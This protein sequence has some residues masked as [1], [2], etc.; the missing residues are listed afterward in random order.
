MVTHPCITF[1]LVRIKK[2]KLSPKFFTFDNVL[3]YLLDFFSSPKHVTYGDNMHILVDLPK[4][5]R[6]FNSKVQPKITIPTKPT[7]VA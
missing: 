4:L 3:K 6:Y 2:K 7:R 1:N 5:Y